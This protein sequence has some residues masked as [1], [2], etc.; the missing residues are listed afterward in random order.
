MLRSARVALQF[1]TRFPVR[2][3]PPASGAELGRSLWWY[4]VVGALLGLVLYATAFALA[5]RPPLLGAALVLCV[6]VLGTGA[7]HLDG[8]ADVADAWVGGHGDRERTLAIMKDVHAGTMAIAA[9]VVVLLLKWSALT[10]LLTHGAPRFALPVLANCV[11]PPLLARAAIPLLLATTA[12]VRP[13]G[14]ATE[15]VAH[16]R[17]PAN[18]LV[19]AAAAA[20]AVGLGALRG[21]LALL[22]AA[23]LLFGLRL[24]FVRRLGG[25]TGDCCGTVIELI[26]ASVLVTLALV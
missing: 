21:L 14:I 13:G 19:F 1:L 3:E 23:A 2:I 16:Q 15:L 20:L 18:V 10:S 11:L 6:W 9:L 26:E 12:Y 4:P 24:A 8:L 7:L 17:R 5:G 22:A 25:V